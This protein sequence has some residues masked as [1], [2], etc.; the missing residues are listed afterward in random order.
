MHTWSSWSWSLQVHLGL[1]LISVK[2]ILVLTWSRSSISTDKT[3]LGI[4]V[5]LGNMNGLAIVSNGCA[6]HGRCARTVFYVRILCIFRARSA[7]FMSMICA[8]SVYY[9]S[10][11]ICLRSVYFLFSSCARCF[12]RSR[13][14]PDLTGQSFYW[15]QVRFPGPIAYFRP[16]ESVVYVMSSLRVIRL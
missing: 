16:V 11:V 4:W 14:H 10:C 8:W 7:Y 15:S 5:D 12:C 3:F 13:V 6:P 2:Y 1:N 9:F